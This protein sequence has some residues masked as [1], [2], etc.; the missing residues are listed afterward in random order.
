MCVYSPPAWL[1]TNGAMDG[2]SFPV[3]IKE[4]AQYQQ[5]WFVCDHP[6]LDAAI[7]NDSYDIIIIITIGRYILINLY[8][9]TISLI[10]QYGDLPYK[11]K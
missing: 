9:C 10:S 3:G 6:I 1:K 11:T 8:Q 2:T 7:R 5:A 4:G